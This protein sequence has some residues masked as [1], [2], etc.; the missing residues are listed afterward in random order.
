MEPKQL[1]AVRPIRR[2]IRL[3]ASALVPRAV[4]LR[5]N[6]GDGKYWC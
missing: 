6:M 3:T 2:P 5:V 4:L 1:L